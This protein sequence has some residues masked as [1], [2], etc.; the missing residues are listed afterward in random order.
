[1]PGVGKHERSAAE[2]QQS[3]QRRRVFIGVESAQEAMRFHEG[4]RRIESAQGRIAANFSSPCPQTSPIESAMTSS[5]TA[6][7]SHQ[8]PPRGAPSAAMMRV[9]SRTL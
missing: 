4:L 8:S 9:L 6:N 3:E 1:M 5:E 2:V 7:A